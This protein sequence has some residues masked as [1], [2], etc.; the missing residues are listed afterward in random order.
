MTEDA[1]NV[2]FGFSRLMY[3]LGFACA[4]LN[5]IVSPWFFGSWEMWWFWPMSAL[6]FGA[7]LFSG[8]GLIAET[9][10]ASSLGSA[11]PIYP[12]LRVPRTGAAVLLCMALF[13]AYAGVRVL[14]PSAPGREMVRMEAERNV[15]LFLTPF[16]LSVSLAV[17][18]TRGRLEFLLRAFCANVVLVAA[19]ALLNHYI[20]G[21][22]YILWAPVEL[23]MHYKGRAIGVFYCP[24]HLCA[25]MNAGIAVFLA[26]AFTPGGGRTGKALTALAAAFLFWPAFLTL[27]RGGLAS[28]FSGILAA[29][30]TF[31]HRGRPP[32]V[33]AVCAVISACAV[34]A[35]CAA[36][37]L[38]DNS[39][40]RRI[41]EHPLY[42]EYEAASK[43][44]D[45]RLWERVS[46]T[47]WYRFDR[48][49]YIAS[50]LRAWRSNPVWG[51]GPG[52]HSNR[53]AEFA[54]TD[55]G[56]LDPLVFPRL[57]NDY[58]HLYEVHSDWTQLLE[59]YGA[60]GFVIFLAFG[61][62]LVYGLSRSQ[63]VCVSVSGE[64]SDVPARADLPNAAD[65]DPPERQSGH[66]RHRHGRR[67]HRH[68]PVKPPSHL[69]KST[70]LAALMCVVVFAV[71]S[72]GDFSLQIPAIVWNLTFII[73]AAFLFSA[74]CGGGK[75]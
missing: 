72:L 17:C 14:F 24:N 65:A 40:S 48:G 49:T 73:S 12:H 9:L 26:N 7:A 52:Q 43:A 4:S 67:R 5:V 70:P 3:V 15:L 34:L 22:S 18:G 50:A 56:S 8:L 41:K 2:K 42:A 19:Y 27:S 33:R 11:F 54:P 37:F 6:V 45:G 21:D 62:V 1:G 60:A 36:L 68:E 61:A 44:G 20:T 38:T 59:E 29:W 10:R 31:A 32:R 57:R 28:L 47:F 63:A 25:F 64:G 35:A 16:L 71:H 69:A 46:D 13:L 30:L 55:D 66:T 23:S 74:D 51:I 39:L 75:S 53:W 58:Y